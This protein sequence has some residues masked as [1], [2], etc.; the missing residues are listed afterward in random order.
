MIR[1][2]IRPAWVSPDRTVHDWIGVTD[3]FFRGFAMREN[4]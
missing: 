1:R 2:N 3:R 4:P